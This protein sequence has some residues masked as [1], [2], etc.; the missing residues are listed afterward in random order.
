MDRLPWVRPEDRKIPTIYRAADLPAANRN[1]GAVRSGAGAVR[2]NGQPPSS[3][4]TAATSA[5]TLRDLSLAG[6]SAVDHQTSGGQRGKSCATASQAT[7]TSDH[8]DSLATSVVSMTDHA[9][10]VPKGRGGGSNT[11]ERYESDVALAEALAKQFAKG[12]RPPPLPTS[13]L[14]PRKRHLSS[15]EEEGLIEDRSRQSKAEKPHRSTDVD[16]NAAI[17]T[18]EPSTR[19][20]SLQGESL[21]C[22][23][24]GLKGHIRRHCTRRADRHKGQCSKLDTGDVMGVQD[25]NEAVPHSGVSTIVNHRTKHQ[26]LLLNTSDSLDSESRP[27]P[28]TVCLDHLADLNVH[29]SVDTTTCGN[30]GHDLRA[31]QSTS[32]ARSGAIAEAEQRLANAQLA[33]PVRG[34]A[35]GPMGLS[36]NPSSTSTQVARMPTHLRNITPV[37]HSLNR[38]T[39]VPR[40]VTSPRNITP[41]TQSLNRSMRPPHSSTTPALPRNE[42]PQ[43]V[44]SSPD[45]SDSE[46]SV[47]LPADP[48]STNAPK[49]AQDHT[50]VGVNIQSSSVVRET[51]GLTIGLAGLDLAVEEAEQLLSE[52]GMDMSQLILE[53]STLRRGFGR[54]GDPEK[55]VAIKMMQTSKQQALELCGKLVGRT[56]WGRTAY[57]LLE[58]AYCIKEF[59]HVRVENIPYAVSKEMI[60]LSLRKRTSVRP[61]RMEGYRKRGCLSW[62]LHVW[63]PSLEAAQDFSRALSRKAA[64]AWRDGGGYYLVPQDLIRQLEFKIM[65]R[66]HNDESDHGE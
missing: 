64:P 54:T 1:R 35:R 14:N 65:E 31:P 15:Q 13:N 12:A 57:A 49:I 28:A 63:L 56:V 38:S 33:Q 66:G 7:D 32:D 39:Q 19:P 8:A 34:L 18:A 6:A 24:C 5:G 23:R 62:T 30:S 25:Q 2:R 21:T 44:V 46:S 36:E 51:I 11:K 41:S 50:N 3:G 52:I 59:F 16:V 26:K 55:G 60:A 42:F 29:E 45:S 53:R 43:V 17:T 47:A 22:S 4:E 48:S 58:K 40:G 9:E 61:L 10:S 20:P 37:A 27:S